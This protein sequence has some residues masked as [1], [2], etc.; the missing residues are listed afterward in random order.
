[1]SRFVRFPCPAKC[2]ENQFDSM[3]IIGESGDRQLLRCCYC[4]AGSDKPMPE[5]FKRTNRYPQFNGCLGQVVESRDHENHV[6]KQQGM[7]PVDHVRVKV[8]KRTKVP[9]PN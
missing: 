7:I 6:A 3:E 8:P 1:M 5:T 2:A 4:G 9:R